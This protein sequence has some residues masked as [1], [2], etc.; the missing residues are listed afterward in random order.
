MPIDTNEYVS[1]RKVASF[2]KHNDQVFETIHHRLAQISS[3]FT[4]NVVDKYVVTN[5]GVGGHYLPHTKYIDDDHLINS[6]GRDAIVIFHVTYFHAYLLSYSQNIII[7][8]TIQ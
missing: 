7:I 2:R 8:I 5:Y 1:L 3:K 6:K 4:T